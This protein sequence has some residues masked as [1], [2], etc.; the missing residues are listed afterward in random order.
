MAYLSDAT[1]KDFFGFS[2]NV[3]WNFKF[4]YNINI[5]VA[6][7]LGSSKFDNGPTWEYTTTSSLISIY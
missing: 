4:S 2:S 6:L 5:H 7:C 3:T 1:R